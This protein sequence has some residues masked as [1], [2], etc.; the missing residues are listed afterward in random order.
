MPIEA[1]RSFIQ[2]KSFRAFQI[3]TSSGEVY[4]VGDPELIQFTPGTVTLLARVPG[5]GQSTPVA[6]IDLAGVISLSFATP[7]TS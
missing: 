5:T 1:L 2:K 4:R 6:V 3:H 7:E